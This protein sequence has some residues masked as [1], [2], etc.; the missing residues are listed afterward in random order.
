MMKGSDM[1]AIQVLALVARSTFRPFDSYD[2]QVFEGTESSNPL[3][4]YADEIGEQYTI[5]IDG[6]R[7]CL[8][9]EHGHESQ[10]LLGENRFA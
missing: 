3:V 6:D 5:I 8:F 1:N 4:H 7:I 9:D 2:R 10:Y